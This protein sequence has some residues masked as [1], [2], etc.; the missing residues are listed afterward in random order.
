ME[1]FLAKLNKFILNCLLGVVPFSRWRK[2]LRHKFGGEPLPFNIE[3]LDYHRRIAYGDKV[4]YSVQDGA[5]IIY[6]EL[7]KDKP[8]LICRYGS[9]ELDIMIQLMRNK[10]HKIKFENTEPMYT[11]AG[12]FPITDYMLC[13]FASEMIEISKNIDVLGV[14]YLDEEHEA[15]EKYCPNIKIVEIDSIIMIS[16]ERP[17]SRY[18]K[19]KKVLVI[20]PFAETIKSQ[21][22]KRRLLFDNPDVLPE[23]DLKVIKAVQSIAEEKKKLP[24]NTWFEAL[25]FMKEQIRQVDFDIALIGCGAYGMFLADYCKSLG[26]KAVHM[27]GATQLLFGIKG[28]RWDNLKIYNEHWVRPKEEEIPQGAN[29]VEGGC[30]W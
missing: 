15:T 6:N 14:R 7:C 10:K 11:N 18:L 26:K 13:R 20:H 28:K 23:F 8:S 27:G 1:K 22:E 12:F 24:F 19:G 25:E 17:W 30:Y 9:L 3:W 4:I 16:Y 21:Y 5:D 2:I 29:K